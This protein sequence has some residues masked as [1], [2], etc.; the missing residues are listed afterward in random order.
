MVFS[1]LFSLLGSIRSSKVAKFSFVNPNADVVRDVIRVLATAVIVA[2]VTRIVQR[3][4]FW[5]RLL[6]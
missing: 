2:I 6:V 4:F 1:S 3:H 5:V